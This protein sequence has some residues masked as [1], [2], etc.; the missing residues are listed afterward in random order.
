MMKRTGQILGILLIAGFVYLNIN[1]WSDPIF[2]RRWWVTMTDTDPANMNFSPTVSLGSE[3]ASELPVADQ[4]SLT[5]SPEALRA[6]E[7]FAL[8][9]D[10]FGLVVVHRGVVQTEWFGPG[11]NRDGLTQSQSMNKTVTAIMVGLAMED[12]YIGSVDDRIGQ[13]IE[14]WRDDPRGDITIENLLRMSSGLAQYVFT[15]NPFADDSAFRFLFSRDRAKVI[16]AT[17]LEWEPGSR[18]D[19]ND[20]NAQLAGMIVERS[21]GRPYADYMRERFWGPLGGQ[22]AELWLDHENGLVMTACCLLAS[23]VDWAKIGVMMLNGGRLNSR[24]IVPERWVERM[25]TPSPL[26]SGYGYLTWLGKGMMG[27]EPPGMEGIER[28]MKEPFLSDDVIMLGGYGGQR[29]FADR[30]ND[31]VVVRLGPSSGMSPLKPHWDN[32]YLLN[33]SIRG[34]R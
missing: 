14:E 33:T 32:T 2:W 13:Y 22:H 31:L 30:E 24:Q 16:L 7:A 21:V 26:Y 25:I 5:V 4:D 1:Y 3:T 34:I 10:S 27:E 20:V 6:V 29:V 12:G 8:D 15:L 23:P 17:A 28:N 18:F 11:W 9:F 19:Y